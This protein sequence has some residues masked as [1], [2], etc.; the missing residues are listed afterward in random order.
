MLGFLRF[1][2][3]S[4]SPKKTYI[5]IEDGY[6]EYLEIIDR[7]RNVDWAMGIPHAH[8][9]ITELLNKGFIR[10]T[11]DNEFI[12]TLIGRVALENFWE[13]QNRAGKGNSVKLG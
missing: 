5:P 11:R 6:C 13:R 10:F 3:K 9:N 12:L 2:R 4:S 1:F 8:E 7:E